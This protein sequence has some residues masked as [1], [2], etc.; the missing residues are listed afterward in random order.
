MLTVVNVH[1]GAGTAYAKW[2]RISP[3][4]S[5]RVGMSAV[6]AMHRV[7]DTRLAVADALSSG[8][9]RFVA[10]GGDGT[11]NLL[12]NLIL[13]TASEDQLRSVKL[14]A[15]GLGSSNDFHKPARAEET[16]FGIPCKVNFDRA[17]QRDVGQVTATLADGRTLTRYWLL[18]GSLGLTARGNRLFNEPTSFLAALKRYAPSAAILL[19]ALRAIRLFRG[20][21]LDVMAGD[22]RAA[23]WLVS[24][25]AIVKSPYFAG[26]MRYDSPYEPLS[27]RFT[28]HLY[29]HVSRMHAVALLWSLAHGRFAPLKRGQTWSVSKLTV[30]GESCFDLELDGEVLQATRAEFSMHSRRLQVCP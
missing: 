26:G 27:G 22:G 13:E 1:A 7:E 14:G 12:A 28:V 16:L 9:S 25:M 24:N 20:I 21:R 18:N 17:V 29:P 2:Q 4:L 30:S 11:V 15:V 3:A 19:S 5:C 6:L 10:A 23:T 8:E